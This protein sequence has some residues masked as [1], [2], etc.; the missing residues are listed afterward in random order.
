MGAMSLSMTCMKSD[1]SRWVASTVEKGMAGEPKR[2]T[3]WYM[4]RNWGTFT[5]CEM[6][7]R[8]HDTT[9]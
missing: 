8:K 2:P 3:F 9:H 6:Q 1:T 7:A 5:I 4:L